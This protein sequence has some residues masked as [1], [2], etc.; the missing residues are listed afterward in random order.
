MVRGEMKISLRIFFNVAQTETERMIRL[1]NDLLKLSKMD[2]REY[3]LNKEV[4]RV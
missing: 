3:E 4:C 1:V 2:S